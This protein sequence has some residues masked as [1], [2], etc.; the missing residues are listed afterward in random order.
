[1]Q[2]RTDPLT[3]AR[4]AFGG[5]IGVRT[6]D[7]QRS[8]REDFDKML[9]RRGDITHPPNTIARRLGLEQNESQTVDQIISGR[10]REIPTRRARTTRSQPVRTAPQRASAAPQGHRGLLVATESFS[11][12]DPSTRRR[13]HVKAEGITYVAPDCAAY[14]LRPSAFAA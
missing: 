2:Y 12:V 8:E 11:Y 1:M 13:E 7:D 10:M 5:L 4:Y 9:V 3:G 6:L 14:A